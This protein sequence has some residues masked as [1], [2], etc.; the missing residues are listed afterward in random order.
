M[1]YV[2]TIF[3]HALSNITAFNACETIKERINDIT[4]TLKHDDE[5]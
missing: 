2:D 3:K 1:A 4:G 5:Q